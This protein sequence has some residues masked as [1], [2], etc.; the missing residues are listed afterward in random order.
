MLTANCA[1]TVKDPLFVTVPTGVA[2]LAVS[3]TV[4]AGEYVPAPTVLLTGAA[5]QVSVVN[6]AF[7]A[8]LNPSG[9]KAVGVIA[10]VPLGVMDA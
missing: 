5:E 8:Q 1:A 2:V 7:G 3:F 4:T 9:K 6:G 10:A